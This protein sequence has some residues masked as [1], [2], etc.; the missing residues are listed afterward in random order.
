MAKH[1]FWGPRGEFPSLGRLYSAVVAILRRGNEDVIDASELR[2]AVP[3]EVIRVLSVLPSASIVAA[4]D[5]VVL[6]ASARALS[7]GLVNR[8]FLTV[9]DIVRLVDR[10]AE[11]G[12]SRE[13]EMRV[14]RPP[15][16]RELGAAHEA[17]E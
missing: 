15:L 10:V 3:D 8:S 11:D 5:G 7:L 17:A 14:R 13:Q 9:A 6:R 4:P 12:Y 16:G 2:P 1:G